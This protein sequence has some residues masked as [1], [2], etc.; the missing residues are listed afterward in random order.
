MFEPVLGVR[1]RAAR[2]RT[3]WF[4]SEVEMDGGPHFFIAALSGFFPGGS[5]YME[6]PDVQLT[7]RGHLYFGATISPSTTL[8]LGIGYMGFKSPE[9]N[10][11]GHFAIGGRIA[12]DFQ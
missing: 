10:Y 1:M 5:S 6:S 11:G 3:P 2:R 8:L 4:A 9:G 12:Y 7:V